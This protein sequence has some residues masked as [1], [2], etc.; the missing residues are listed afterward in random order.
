[1]RLVWRQ[2]L[3]VEGKHTSNGAI[4][5][6]REGCHAR[7]VARQQLRARDGYLQHA[8]GGRDCRARSRQLPVAPARGGLLR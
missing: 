2:R 5:D 4:P 6:E 7:I 3:G 1:M 8:P